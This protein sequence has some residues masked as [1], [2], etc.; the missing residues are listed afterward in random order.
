ML[1]I[2]LP[3]TNVDQKSNAVLTA[4]HCVRHF[5]QTPGD[6]VDD[7]VVW[8]VFEMII[9]IVF[10]DMIYYDDEKYKQDPR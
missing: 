7:H 9:L 1:L 5:T 10:I 6:D 2:I 3:L 4:A 8:L